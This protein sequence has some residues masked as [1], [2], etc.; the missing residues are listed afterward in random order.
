MPQIMN[1]LG[2]LF[3]LLLVVMGF[4]LIIVLH[5]LGHFLAARWAGVRVLAF[6]V[7][8][9][10]A[11]FSW[12]KGLGLRRGSSE[13][14]YH[15]L[16]GARAAG[17]TAVEGDRATHHAVSPTEYRLNVFPFGGYVKMLG[18]DDADP[19]A[20]SDAP[21]SYTSAK[22]WKRM[23]I[24]SAGVAANLVV[25]AVLFILVF[26]VGLKTEP[27]KVGDVAPGSPAASAVA[28]NAGQAGV[29]EPGLQPGDRVLAIGSREPNSFNDLVLASA[30]AA[31]GATIDLTVERP[32]VTEPLR[33]RIEP[34]EDHATRMLQLGIGPASSDRLMEVAPGDDAS[35]AEFARIMERIGLSGVEPGMRLISADGQPIDSAD[36]LTRLIRRSP[37]GS[38]MTV[39]FAD[40][41]GREV[42]G[43]IRPE[44]VLQSAEFLVRKNVF[45]RV[46]HL[47]GLT[48]PMRVAATMPPADEAGLKKGDVFVRIGGLEWPSIPEG[49]AEIGR[50]AGGAVP[51]AVLRT[52]E[53]G[54]PAIV[55]LGEVPVSRKG[56][57]GF[58]VEDS[59][60]ADTLIAPWPRLPATDPAGDGL[61]TQLPAASLHLLPGSRI[62][63]VAGEPVSNFSD[64]RAALRLATAAAAAAGT[65]AEVPLRIELPL[66]AARGERPV[67]ERAWA[68]DAADV[69]ALHA[70]GW[71][72]PVPTWFFQ[73]EQILLRADGPLG[74]IV[75]GLEE[76][77]RVM[78]ST[79]LTFARLFQG[80][81]RV[82]H[83][84]G[85]VG[86]AHVGTVIASRGFIWL[87]FFLALVSVNLAVVNFLP[88]PIADGGHMVF[89]IYEQLT[90]KP[91]SVAVQNAAAMVGL[92][93]IVGLF[94]VV[95]FNDISRLIAP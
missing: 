58:A 77:H 88:V 4:G 19:T 8:F 60:D 92:V 81:V 29:A 74:A 72:N 24:I 37:D 46:D 28:L 54:S 18:Q 56:T 45:A 16:L 63:A 49:M 75:M 12:R 14:E 2:T 32:G 85:P 3:D 40:D 34:R 73:R 61:A 82:E 71:E 1:A 38:P 9:G 86:I 7:G 33:F 91:V 53:S 68:L 70:L 79:Y 95:T 83:L 48:A 55:D 64:L 69:A 50:H 41:S 15:Q 89:L 11:L 6:A 25:A 10:P 47:L 35:H 31:R 90:G 27:A 23:V 59:G 21:D 67:E 62:L 5:E 44:P 76:T 66:P 43:T 84:R 80:T 39:A 93:L 78:M 22:V 94:L 42:T 26:M 13:R 87:L 65:S 51:V 57:I 52:D 30:M 20:R 36:Q 17:A